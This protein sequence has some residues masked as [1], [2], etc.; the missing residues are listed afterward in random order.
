MHIQQI[1]WLIE[2]Y[3]EYTTDVQIVAK[4]VQIPTTI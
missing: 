3:G 2:K 1:T 4:F